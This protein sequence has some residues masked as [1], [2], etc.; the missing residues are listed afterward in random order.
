MTNSCR[1]RSLRPLRWSRSKATNA[2]R[3]GGPTSATPEDR[4]SGSDPFCRRRR[5]R[6]RERNRVSS[7]PCFHHRPDRGEGT[8]VRAIMTKSASKRRDLIRTWRRRRA[9]DSLRLSESCGGVGEESMEPFLGHAR[10]LKEEAHSMNPNNK[11]PRE[12]MATRGSL[13]L[14]AHGLSGRE[15]GRWSLRGRLRPL[16]GSRRCASGCDR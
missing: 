16:R 5:P 2:M 3:P 10:W 12:A 15:R 8:E 7:G 14:I 11:E 13:L 1:A 9:G 6:H 4:Q